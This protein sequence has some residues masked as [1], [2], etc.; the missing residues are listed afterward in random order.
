[1]KVGR[2]DQERIGEFLEEVRHRLRPEEVET[3]FAVE[4]HRIAAAAQDKIGRS[5]R[6]ARAAACP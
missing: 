6:R 1:M 4:Q 3:D 2:D 5:A